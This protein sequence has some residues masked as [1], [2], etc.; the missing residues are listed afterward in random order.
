MECIENQSEV[1]SSRPQVSDV[2]SSIIFNFE[3]SQR[4]QSKYIQRSRGSLDSADN[5][6]MMR[7]SQ[8]HLIYDTE[9]ACACGSRFSTCHVNMRLW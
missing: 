7:A 2:H 1:A 4:A 3:T 5:P 8:H 6:S 9:L